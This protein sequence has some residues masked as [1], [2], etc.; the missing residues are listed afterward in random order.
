MQNSIRDNL[1]KDDIIAEIQLQLDADFENKKC[2]VIVEGSDDVTFFRGKLFCDADIKES[3]SG[4]TG[5]YEIVDFFSDNRIIGICDMD[6]APRHENN[7]VFYYDYSCLEMMLVS[8]DDVFC[9]F[10]Y[11]YYCGHESPIELRFGIL[12][13]LKWIS[14]FRKLNY[15]NSWGIRFTAI[16]FNSAYDGGRKELNETVLLSQIVTSN[17]ES[18]KLDDKKLDQVKEETEIDLDVNALLTITNGHDF[19]N[20]FQKLCCVNGKKAQSSSN[21]MFKGLVCS[22]SSEAMERT[23]LYSAIQD[24]Q[25]DKRIM[26][27]KN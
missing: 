16:N 11:T 2:I 8:N 9:S 22:F 25:R 21:E 17:A 23:K 19:M 3:F 4:K 15:I 5:V 18:L 10:C 1:T 27:L 13:A 14:S 24:Y 20:Y 26:I 12:E 6:Y 7:R